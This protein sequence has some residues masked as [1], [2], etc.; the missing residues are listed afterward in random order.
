MNI[1]SDDSYS[2][3]SSTVYSICQRE[4][5][6]QSSSRLN[7]SN[8]KGSSFYPTYILLSACFM[9]CLLLPRT[10]FMSTMMLLKRTLIQ[11]PPFPLKHVKNGELYSSLLWHHWTPTVHRNRNCFDALTVNR[12]GYVWQFLSIVFARSTPVGAV[13]SCIT[14]TGCQTVLS[15]HYIILW[16]TTKSWVKSQV[17][18]E[19][20]FRKPFLIWQATI[21]MCYEWVCS[22]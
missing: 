19:A 7:T 15:W 16:T 1:Y 11:L 14:F 8:P 10:H 18:L 9:R 21:R 13:K 2:S 3:S 6:A 12:C 5:K 20:F 17:A 4:G 22:S